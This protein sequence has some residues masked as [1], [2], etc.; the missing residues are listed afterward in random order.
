[1]TINPNDFYTNGKPNPINNKYLTYTPGTVLEYH[2]F[3]AEGQLTE[4]RTVTVTNQTK[5]I[6][7]VTCT[8]VTDVV[9]DAETN[10]LIEKTE[11]YFAQDNA[12]NV[13]Y[14]GEQAVNYVYDDVTGKLLEK[15]TQGSWLAGTQTPSG[16]IAEPGIAME[17][18][19]KVGDTYNQENAPDLAEDYARITSLKGNTSL[20]EFGAL[21]NLLVTLD[22]N[23]LDTVGGK[24]TEQENKYYS[25]ANIPGFNGEVF[26]QTYELDG[27][28]YAL[29]ETEQLWSIKVNGN[30]Q[31]VQAMASFGASSSG[32][33]TPLTTASSEQQGPQNPLAASGHHA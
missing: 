7:G 6:D 18:N 25:N 33:A 27:N 5:V 17:A 19:P 24:L 29:A 13:W 3:D 4:I 22:L 23:P 26:S 2:T 20:D 21:K 28:K 31:L 10:K 30:T 8:V 1:M 12:G 11:D 9:R 16:A 14:F 15:N 32:S